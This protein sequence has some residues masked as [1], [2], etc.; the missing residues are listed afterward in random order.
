[1]IY[2]EMKCE[3]EI[4]KYLIYGVKKKIMMIK[5]ETCG[6]KAVSIDLTCHSD[7]I[8]SWGRFL[9]VYLVA[10]FRSCEWL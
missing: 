3:D 1:M 4:G 8:I 5:V 10:K 2:V 7:V 6:W 9:Q